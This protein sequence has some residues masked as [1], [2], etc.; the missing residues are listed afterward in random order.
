[1]LTNFQEGTTEEDPEA[2]LKWPNLIGRDFA[3]HYMRCKKFCID[4]A[5]ERLLQGLK[6]QENPETSVVASFGASLFIFA[7]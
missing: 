3:A 2:R 5:G 6:Q 4:E 1:L 7:G